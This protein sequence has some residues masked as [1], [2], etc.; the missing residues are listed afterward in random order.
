[1]IAHN[2]AASKVWITEYGAPTNGPGTEATPGNYQ[3]GSSPDHVNEL[4]QAQMATEAVATIRNYSWAGPLFWYGYR[5]IGTDASN[6]ENFYG[7][8]RNDG[9]HKPAYAALQTAIA[10]K[11]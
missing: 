6:T 5:D 11:H 4:L 7:L 2:D 1:M 9:S 8:L 10:G 3:I